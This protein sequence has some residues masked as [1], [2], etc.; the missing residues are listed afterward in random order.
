[1]RGIRGVSPGE[2]KECYGGEN[3]PILY[4]AETTGPIEM[5]LGA[6][7]GAIGKHLPD[8]PWTIDAPSLRACVMQLIAHSRALCREDAS[9]RYHYC[10]SLFLEDVADSAFSA[11]TL[12]VG[13]Q[14][15]HPACKKTEWWGA[16]VWLSVWSKVQTCIWPS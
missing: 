13:W 3:V 15:G 6:G 2:E 16:G 8:T 11:L 4:L 10:S 7:R 12:L 9:C 5:V 14:E 1:M